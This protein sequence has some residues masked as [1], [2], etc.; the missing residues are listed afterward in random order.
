MFFWNTLQLQFL[1]MLA[2]NHQV[3]TIIIYSIRQYHATT[4]FCIAFDALVKYHKEKSLDDIFHKHPSLFP[5]LF[6]ILLRFHIGKI[7][8]LTETYL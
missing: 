8:R 4:K 1:M 7:L 2:M 6:T 3:L 5:Y